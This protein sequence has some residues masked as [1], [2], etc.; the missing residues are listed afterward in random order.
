MVSFDVLSL[1]T[2]VV[3]ADSLE[4]LSNHFEDDILALFKH[5]LTSTYSYFDGQF[6]EQMD[7]VAKAHHLL[8]MKFFMEDFE[9]KATEQ[10]HTNL[11]PGSDM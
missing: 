2:K 5:I 1:F 11:Y 9:K 8:I 3:I 10:Q 7:G 6:Y 4:L